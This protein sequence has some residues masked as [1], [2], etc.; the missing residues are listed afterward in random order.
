MNHA[1]RTGSSE[2]RVS[3][4][5]RNASPPRYPGIPKIGPK[6]AASLITGHGPIEPFPAPIL[7]A[8]LELALLF[9]TLATLRT[10]APLFTNVEALRWRGP[11]DAFA[12][13][14][15]RIGAP[16]LVTRIAK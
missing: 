3:R 14:A 10:D 2:S 8:R 1:R 15:E 16:G 7:G 11:T 4:Q 13:T 9:K 5:V 12:S 6:T